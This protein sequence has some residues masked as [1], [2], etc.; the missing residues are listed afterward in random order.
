MEYKLFHKL[1]EYKLYDVH[2]SLYSTACKNNIT[3]TYTIII[4]KVPRIC[5][6][7]VF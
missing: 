1:Y 3:F 4:L 6:N 5:L 2:G 7:Q